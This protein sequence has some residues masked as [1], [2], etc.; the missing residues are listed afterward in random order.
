MDRRSPEPNTLCV[1]RCVCV[2]YD[3]SMYASVYSKPKGRGAGDECICSVVEIQIGFA[4]VM[5]N[6]QIQEY[7]QSGES[8]EQRGNSF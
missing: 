3:H 2:L 1:P 4:N 7:M 8:S 6:R 5:D